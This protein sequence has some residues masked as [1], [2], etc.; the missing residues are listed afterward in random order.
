MQSLARMSD[1]A[2]LA[3]RLCDLSRHLKLDIQ[4]SWLRRPVAEL[5][6]ELEAAGLT[7]RP[8]VWLSQE[9]FSPAGV[10]GIAIPFYLA[11]PRLRRL[12]RAQM[13]EVEG[14]S[15]LSCLRILRHEA[16]HALQHAFNLHRRKGWREHFGAST[17]PYPDRYRPNPASKRYVI[18]LDLW[19]AQSHPD[20]DFAETFAEWL[21]PGS[22]WRSRYAGWPALRKLEYIDGL[23][24]ELGSR[25]P[26]VRTRRRVEPLSELKTTLEEYYAEKRQRYA[27]PQPTRYDADL[28]R[29]FSPA[30]RNGKET[31]AQFMRRHQRE[32]QHLVLRFASD[33]AHALDIVWREMRQRAA[34][35]R[36]QR[37]RAERDLVHE[38][39]VSVAMHTVAY[40][41]APRRV[42]RM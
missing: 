38:L 31:A 5:Y 27:R 37:T 18:H 35:L 24:A 6:V 19:Y 23:I 41:H 16:G 12:E 20:E 1:E 40:V 14:G 9:W 21:R 29:L 7:L 26:P 15:H 30:G 34:K 8:H 3:L 42:H 33:H 17:V 39:G 28:L 32:I 25:R 10:P 2:L 4:R 22:R 36:L 11:H 13:G